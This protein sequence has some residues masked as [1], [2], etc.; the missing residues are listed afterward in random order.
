MP[1]ASRFFPKSYTDGEP[2]TDNGCSITNEELTAYLRER[3]S[4]DPDG[5]VVQATV[6]PGGRSKETILVKLEGF[7]HLPEEIIVR[8]D[9]PVGLL[10]NHAADE[11]T[12]IKTV[13][14]YGGVAIPEPFFAEES[15]AMLGA[16]TALVM[17]ARPRHQ[18][19]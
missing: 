16:G 15:S 17:A 2:V 14:E 11:Y 6:I 8:K 19:R 13:F 9:R 4:D 5:R 1:C 12:V 18:G 3:F 10:E 7:S